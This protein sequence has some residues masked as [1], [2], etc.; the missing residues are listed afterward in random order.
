LLHI[1]GSY[2]EGGG[3]ILRTAVA[4]S[5]LTKTPL[6]INNIRANRPKPGIKS[7]HYTAIKIMEELCNAETDGLTIGSPNLTFSPGKITSG[8]Y[9]FDIGTA[10]SIMLVL[11]A[12]ILCSL[13]T[14]S[15]ITLKVTGGT[16]VKWSPSWDYFKHVFLTLIKKIGL[17]VNVHL[18]KRGYYPKG[19]GEVVLTINPCKDIQP[20]YLDKKQ[21]FTTVEGIINIANLPDHISKR[22]KHAAM[23]TLLNKNLDA[24]LKIEKTTS[25]SAGIGIS[26][27]TR[28]HDA[29]LG[30]TILGERGLSAEKIGENVATELIHEVKSGATLDIHALDQILPFVILAKENEQSVCIVREISCHS[31]TNMWL[32][33]KFFSNQEIFHVENRNDFKIIKIN[34]TGYL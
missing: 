22:M 23:K 1:D 15:P 11:Q 31:Q 18:I 19:G 33:R 4:L 13:R 28:T 21:E 10:G 7:Q 32:I 3:Q 27:W 25:L 16:D 17:N 5:V 30:A 6:E 8:D 34:G 9:H 26:L 2:G 20:L 12:C 29:I 14:N 24:R